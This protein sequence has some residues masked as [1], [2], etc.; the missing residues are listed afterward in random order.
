MNYELVSQCQ[1]D[2][3]PSDILGTCGKTLCHDI[4]AALKPHTQAGVLETPDGVSHGQASHIGHAALT[5]VVGLLEHTGLPDAEAFL[6]IGCVF[7][8]GAGKECGL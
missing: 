4:A 7:W 5:L 6:D 2:D 3:L 8:I 1:V